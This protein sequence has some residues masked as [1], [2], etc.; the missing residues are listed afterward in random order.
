MAKEHDTENGKRDLPPY[1]AYRSFRNWLAS[2]KIGLPDKVDRSIL[3]NLSGV[4]QSQLLSTLRFLRLISPEGSTSEELQRLV[5]SEG[6]EHQ[7]VF[8]EV[9]RTAY[10]F[11]FSS[12]LN[13]LRATPAQLAEAFGKQG[14][15]GDTT[16]KAVLFF[17]LAAKDA[18]IQV[19]PDL[20][21]PKAMR[22][23][24][25]RKRTSRP[26]ASG[27]SEEDKVRVEPPTPRGSIAEK[28]PYDFLIGILDVSMEKE[29]QE[30]VWTLIRYLKRRETA[31]QP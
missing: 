1:I 2:R 30:A 26:N 10:G 22:G 25:Q 20:R 12:D 23:T 4:V 19:S 8:S 14:V 27:D 31:S 5:R 9:L 17:L 6:A 13:L 21:A 11:L 28:S 18:G 29:E 16:R 7:K 3:G 15:S 24:T